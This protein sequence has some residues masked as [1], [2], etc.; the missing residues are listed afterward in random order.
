MVKINLPAKVFMILNAKVI[1][2][3]IKFCVDECKAHVR[4]SI[5]TL[6]EECQTVQAVTTLERE[7]SLHSMQF[8]VG[9]TWRYNSDEKKS[10]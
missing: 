6:P 2:R 5:L 1:K 9:V 10:K 4:N 3:Q 7:P 8:C